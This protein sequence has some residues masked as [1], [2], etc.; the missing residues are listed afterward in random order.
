MKLKKQ[1]KVVGYLIKIFQLK[2]D[3]LKTGESNGLNYPK[4]PLRSSAILN[5]EN[6]DKYCFLWSISA[7]LQPCENSHPSRVRNY[8]Q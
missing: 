3:F 7:Y 1:R 4:L 8:L 5:R 2:S 6:I